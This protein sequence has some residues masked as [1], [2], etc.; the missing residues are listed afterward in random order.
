MERITGLISKL[1][2]VDRTDERNASYFLLE[3]ELISEGLDECS[4]L[5]RRYLQIPDSNINWKLWEIVCLESDIVIGG[6]DPTLQLSLD[7]ESGLF[8]NSSVGSS[9]FVNE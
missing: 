3:Q 2:D 9:L 5:Q 4:Y 7:D 8:T 6:V 1:V